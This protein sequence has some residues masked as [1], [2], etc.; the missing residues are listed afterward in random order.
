MNQWDHQK[1]TFFTVLSGSNAISAILESTIKE[2]RF[3]IRLADLMKKKRE[4]NS[5]FRKI[6]LKKIHQTL[7]NTKNTF[8]NSK[9]RNSTARRTCG[10]SLPPSLRPSPCSASS[11]VAWAV[12]KSTQKDYSSCASYTSGH[13]YLDA[14]KASCLMNVIWTLCEAIGRFPCFP[15]QRGLTAC[16]ACAAVQRA[17]A[18]PV[19]VHIPLFQVWGSNFSQDHFFGF[20]LSSNFLQRSI[21]GEYFLNNFID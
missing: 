21:N 17:V 1:R 10:N 12:H 16:R 19:P 6:F 13:D 2:K 9:R 20:S 15:L 11:P 14:E 7:I 8:A 5:K 4:E 3:K 18:V